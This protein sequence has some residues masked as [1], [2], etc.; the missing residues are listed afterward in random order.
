MSRVLRGLIA[1]PAEV[2][3]SFLASCEFPISHNLFSSSCAKTIRAFVMNGNRTQVET[4]RSWSQLTASPN[5]KH[6]TAGSRSAKR[7]RLTMRQKLKL[8][9]KLFIEQLELFKFESFPLNT[10]TISQESYR[11]SR[12]GY[13]VGLTSAS[14]TIRMI[15]SY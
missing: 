7:C 8:L 14:D 5:C 3:C 9:A 1:R 2:R 11:A 12:Q 15:W 6:L 10:L 4:A 13:D